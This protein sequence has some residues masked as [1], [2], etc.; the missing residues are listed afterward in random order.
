MLYPDRCAVCD[1]VIEFDSMLC[2]RCRAV[3]RPI[4]G[5]TCY[6]CGKVLGESEKIYCYDCSR[7]LHYFD[8]GFSVFEYGDVKNSLY[9]FKYSGRAEYAHFYA[10][11]ANK[12]LGDTL[13]RLDVDAMIP[14]PIHKKRE[15][16]RGYNQAYLLAKELSAYINV[17]VRKD[18]VKR[19][20]AT[21]PLKRLS[22][23][24]RKNN[25]KNAFIIE[26][27]DVKLKKILLI[28]DIYTT[29]AT[30]DTVS[31]LLRQAGIEEIYFLTVAIGAGL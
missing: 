11:A 17:P 25:L 13:R 2:D 12:L 28:D 1:E 10:Y 19:K 27:N 5:D 18:I 16:T 31:A 23:Q 9:R 20:K 22:E 4:S 21:A 7:K 29:G 15:L 3:I 6:K 14:I 26:S 8:R 30:I 24:Q